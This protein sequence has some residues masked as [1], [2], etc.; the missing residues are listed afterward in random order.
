MAGSG[1]TISYRQLEVFSNQ[2]AQL[3]RSLGLAAGDSVAIWLRNNALYLPIC[4]AAHRAGLYFTP[5]A[6]HLTPEEAA[7]IISDT[8]A[9]V[10]ITS[11]DIG[12]ALQRL[13]DAAMNTGE[14]EFDLSELRYF[15]VGE[16][17]DGV[18]DWQQACS[19]MPATRLA[20]ETAGQHRVYSSGTTGRPKGIH[21]PLSGAA[22]DEPLP[23]YPLM[24]DLFRL[25]E[26]S[27]YLS[28]A[29][30]Y[31]TAPLVYC[32]TMHSIGGTVLI[33]EKFEPEA[34]MQTVQ[35]YCANAVQMVPT[36][37]V[38]LLKLPQAVRD[39]YDL[40]SLNNVIHAA[41]PC[42]VP[43]KHQMIDWLGPVL[44]EYYSGSEGNGSTMISSQEWLAKPGS[45]GKAVLGVMHVCNDE[46]HELPSGQIGL[47]YFEGGNRF[48]YN[49]DEAKTKQAHH[50]SKPGW[51]TLGDVGYIDEDG[52]LFLTDRKN[53]MIISG[54][55]NIYPQEIENVLITHP[56]VADVAVF[57]VP[58]SEF[59][60]EVKAV[61]QPLD[62]ETANDSLE[63]T[64]LDYCREQLSAV[65]CPRSIDFDPALPRM[66]NGK[67]Y[68][69][70]LRERYW[71]GKDNSL[72]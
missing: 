1:E 51:S 21:I 69:K 9:K 56:E 57:G 72:V 20:D 37:F 7:Y 18:V 6:S 40:S 29:P 45:V 2:G 65:K 31:H 32:M 11:K 54:G 34:F 60:E 3:F 46:G 26:S 33:M 22:A 15:S 50:P 66:D 5:V 25:S 59:G 67:L 16:G 47:V 36:M 71:Q 52:Y 14:S 63:K 39:Q 58:H 17:I 43:I 38:R 41:A 23:Y 27:V 68:K 19:R 53:F 62:V 35:K 30:L 61:V 13:R 49:K 10:L 12:E 70:G 24:R 8:E 48:E 64:L 28:P 42:P 4:W 44:L 55:V